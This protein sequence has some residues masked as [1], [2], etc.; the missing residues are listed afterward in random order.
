MLGT[1][2]AQV[3]VHRKPGWPLPRDS[4]SAAAPHRCALLREYSTD[5]CT[6]NETYGCRGERGRDT[7]WTSGGCRGE[8]TCGSSTGEAVVCNVLREGR[9][10]CDCEAAQPK[11]LAGFQRIHL[12]RG[13]RTVVSVAL[14][15]STFRR[16]SAE[17]G[18][19]VVPA[20]QYG[21]L[22]GSSS[23]DIRGSAVVTVTPG[24][25]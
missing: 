3:Y 9:H 14:P 16:W 18:Q 13:Q 19:W 15:L 5:R 12:T 17:L 7:L 8:F 1:G 25:V 10:R 23:R 22:V 21:V 20:G 24:S 2:L 4:S 11:A 6:A